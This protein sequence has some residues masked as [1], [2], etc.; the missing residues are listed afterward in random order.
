MVK[1]FVPP[2][3]KPAASWKTIYCV[4]IILTTPNFWWV[5]EDRKDSSGLTGWR[6]AYDHRRARVEVTPSGRHIDVLG[7]RYR[8][9]CMLIHC[10]A[11]R[12]ESFF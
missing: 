11:E 6:R 9:V 2:G 1:D 4:K 10:A 3:K 12:E 5:W 8:L 7:M